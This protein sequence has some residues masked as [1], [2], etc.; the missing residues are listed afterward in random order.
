MGLGTFHAYAWE[1][2]HPGM[3][4]YRGVVCIDTDGSSV[5]VCEILFVTIVVLSPVNSR[6][7]FEHGLPVSG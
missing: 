4:A 2:G 6:F 5:F 1:C 3:R 7:L